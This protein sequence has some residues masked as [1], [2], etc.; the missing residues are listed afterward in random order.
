LSSIGERDLGFA[1]CMSV[2][3][4]QYFVG[5]LGRVTSGGFEA[6]MMG[7]VVGTQVVVTTA[8][9]VEVRFLPG[10]KPPVL[11][12]PGGHTTAATPIG[13]DIYTEIGHSVLCFSRPGY[14]RTEVGPLTAAEFVPL[15]VQTSRHLGIDRAAAA[16][17]VSFGG[18]QAI[19][20][21]VAAPDLVPRLILHSCAPSALTFPDTR[22]ERGAVPLV[23]GPRTQR[24]TWAAIRRMVASD[25]GLR[26]MMK[27]L[28]RLPDD[29]WWP[30]MSDADRRSARATFDAMDS[31]SGFVNDIRHASPR[32]NPYRAHIQ[33]QVTAPTL[34]TASPHDGGVSFRHAHNF[35]ETIR[36]AQ[37]VETTAPT[38]FYWI[39]QGRA[40]I[41]DAV[42]DFLLG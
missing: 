42:S 22:L 40:G 28:T 27:S 32:L 9:P 15:V 12:F 20:T 6:G 10:E 37:L 16:V 21:A 11:L 30:Q 2:A 38:H 19:H 7:V 29:R 39:G 35:I 3:D 14:G 13:E 18:L 1:T 31:G 24:V 26:I 33:T 23:F 36:Q 5:I 17:G 41:T 4:S 34:V 8:G 25:A